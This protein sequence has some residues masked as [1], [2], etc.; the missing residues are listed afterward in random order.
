[1]IVFELHI[2]I[3]ILAGDDPEQLDLQ[4]ALHGADSVVVHEWNDHTRQR[5]SVTT[6]A[7]AIHCFLS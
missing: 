3:Y 6:Q 4:V 7:P 1:M 2:P 5:D